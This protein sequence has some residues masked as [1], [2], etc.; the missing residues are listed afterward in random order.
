M[1]CFHFQAKLIVQHDLLLGTDMPYF[2]VYNLVGRGGDLRLN[3]IFILVQTLLASGFTT[4]AGMV[5][6]SRCRILRN[7][8]SILSPS[9]PDFAD[10]GEEGGGHSYYR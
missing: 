6:T 5:V 4:W 7:H 8:S 3:M 2:M 1:S 10:K 9:P